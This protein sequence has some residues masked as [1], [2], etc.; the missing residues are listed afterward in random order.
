MRHESLQA[1]RELLLPVLEPVVRGW[2]D[3]VTVAVSAVV[4]F[5]TLAIILYPV[6]Y[7]LNEQYRLVSMAP[8][9]YGIFAGSTT[10]EVAQVVAAGNA[11]SVDVGNTAVIATMARVTILAPFLIVGSAYLARSKDA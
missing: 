4:V 3:Q 2:A 7:H 5:G 8:S 10:D 9:A 1:G 6:L 11:I